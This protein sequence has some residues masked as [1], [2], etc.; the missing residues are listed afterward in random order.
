MNS[1]SFI[2]KTIVLDQMRQD[3]AGITEQLKNKLGI[4]LPAS[5]SWIFSLLS[6][7]MLLL[8]F[9]FF[10]ESI[11]NITV[12]NFI[13]FGVLLFNFLLPSTTA[14]Q[15]FSRVSNNPLNDL[16]WQSHYNR[17]QLL[18]FALISEL[19]MFWLHELSLEIIAIFV[20]FQISPNFMAGI[21]LTLVWILLVSFIYISK[22]KNLVLN[23]WGMK[24][25]NT[26]HSEVIYFIKLLLSSCLI[27]ILSKLLLLPLI[28]KPITNNIY[29]QGL[30]KSLQYF[31]NTVKHIFVIR[32][33]FVKNIWIKWSHSEWSYYIIGI[34]F[35][36]YIGLNVYYFIFQSTRIN[37][38]SK[39]NPMIL[40]T[41]QNPF[42]K[43]Y[44][45]L[46]RRI[47]PNNPWIHRDLVVMER[48][49]NT[50]NIPQKMFLFM[51]PAIS[52]II[53]FS[54]FLI[55]SVN[56]YSSFIIAF[57]F[58]SWLVVSQTIG[59]WLMN[60]PIL[61]P[62]SELRQIELTKLSPHLNINQYMSSKR[63]LIYILLSPVQIVTTIMFILGALIIKG[64]IIEFI[65]GIVGVWVLFFVN[66]LVSTYWL[67]LCSRFD[68]ANIYMIR[69]D[70]Y[71]SKTL[72]YF[73][74][75]PNRAISGVLFL[76]FFIAVFIKDSLGLSL[77]YDSFLFLIAL[78][79]F[80]W[81]FFVN[82]KYKKRW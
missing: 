63:K 64:S 53:G 11:T 9:A 66:V 16:L 25:E 24:V 52:P 43:F 41:S 45:W 34:F 22:L 65:I 46:S 73:F 36:I 56:S 68:Y 38:I 20:I 1:Y 78:G 82:K 8:L 28:E 35:L 48:T 71:E 62:S 49:I 81:Y 61:H 69:M 40:L 21:L 13:V 33:E 18:N 74:T 31:S 37:F 29:Q 5:L 59:I 17:N 47:Y 50:C 14:R 51:P 67:Q 10:F 32:F 42:F 44:Q 30:V 2:L 39:K 55:G 19:L 79:V 3:F 77:L 7:N 70:T 72:Q 76:L 26:I 57:W 75:I 80:S 27:W 54:I 6:Q 60:Y 15:H 58:V 23:T 12:R 4:K